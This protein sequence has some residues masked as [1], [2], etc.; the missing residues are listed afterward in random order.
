VRAG[1]G[2]K[3]KDISLSVASPLAALAAKDFTVEIFYALEEAE[4]GPLCGDDHLARA[5][6]CGPGADRGVLAGSLRAGSREI[7]FGLKKRRAGP[8]P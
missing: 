5:P 6:E 1:L 4:P 7:A 3:R 2:Y 8:K